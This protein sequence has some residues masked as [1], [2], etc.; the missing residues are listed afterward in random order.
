MYKEKKKGQ[1]MGNII[2][3]QNKSKKQK[4]KKKKKNL[5]KNHVCRVLSYC[6]ETFFAEKRTDSLSLFFGEF[7]FSVVHLRGIAKTTAG[8]KSRKLFLLLFY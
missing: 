7:G 4:R 2:T 8:R 5:R 6:C 3:D 1:K